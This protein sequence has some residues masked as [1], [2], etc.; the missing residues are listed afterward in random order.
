M[1]THLTTA[2]RRA[3]SL[4]DSTINLV[5]LLPQAEK[6]ELILLRAHLDEL[7]EHIVLQ[8]DGMPKEEKKFWDTIRDLV[9]SIY[10]VTEERLATISHP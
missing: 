9:C 5:T 4:F 6:K 1:N 2:Q 3:S 7:L 8:Y 10:R